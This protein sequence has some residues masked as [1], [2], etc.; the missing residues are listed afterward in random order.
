MIINCIAVEDEPKAMEKLESFIRQIPFLRLAGSFYDGLS[1]LNYLNHN[2]VD[3][4]FLDI[5]ME[6]LTGV[7]LLES[8]LHPPFVI[9]TTAYIQY[10]VKGYELMA[11]D[12]LLKPYSFERF[13][14]AANKAA[15]QMKLKTQHP[16]NSVKPTCFFIKTAYQIERIKFDD[17]LYIQG[18]KD[19]LGI[20]TQEKKIMCLQNFAS[21]MDLL[22]CEDFIRVHKSYVVALDKIESI[23]HH[24]IKIGGTIIPISNTYQQ[25][26]YNTLEKNRRLL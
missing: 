19:Y 9:F 24:R 15:E 13:L 7:Q 20:V 1:A 18:M 17:I 6:N 16:V 14:S 22:P 23:V 11:V 4:M 8:L 5:Q 26:F 21:L 2:Q 25:D 3:L 10:A 12:Y